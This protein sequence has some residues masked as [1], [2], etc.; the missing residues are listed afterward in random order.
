MNSEQG[1]MHDTVG[2]TA[3]VAAR[4]TDEGKGGDAGWAN[5]ELPTMNNAALLANL[6]SPAQSGHEAVRGS[7][8]A[9]PAAVRKANPRANPIICP[10]L[11]N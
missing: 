7:D 3:V 5:L 2:D 4:S 11:H 10:L 6:C 9:A 8:K 1:L